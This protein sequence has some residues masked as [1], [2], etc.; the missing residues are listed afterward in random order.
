M[1]PNAWH[2][3][4][5][6]RFREQNRFRQFSA[7]NSLQT[8]Q[9]QYN[10]FLSMA[11][12]IQQPPAI[13]ALPRYFLVSFAGFKHSQGTRICPTGSRQPAIRFKPAAALG[14][15]F[16]NGIA[17]SAPCL[18]SRFT[19]LGLCTVCSGNSFAH[20]HRPGRMAQVYIGSHS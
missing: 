10:L 7:W 17:W 4:R 14:E 13:D 15:R 11:R 8:A 5:G 1:M 6:Q 18:F 2:A 20:R 19:G 12:N 16:V 9:T 3:R